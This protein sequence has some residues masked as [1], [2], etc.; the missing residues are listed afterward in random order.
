MAGA[1]SG[2]GTGSGAVGVGLGGFG[3]GG[4]AGGIVTA[5]VTGATATTGASSGGI[6]AQSLGGGGGDGGFAIAGA[7]S[8]AGTG[9]GSVGVGIGGFGGDGGGGSDVTLGVTGDTSTL[10]GDSAGVTAQSIG[11]GGGNGGFSVGAALSFAGKGAGAVGV[12]IGGFGGAGGGAGDVRLTL[13]GDTDTRGIRSTGILAQSIGGGG[14]N[15]GFTV[16]GSVAGASTGA[17]ALSVGIGGFGGDAS[18][19]G[20][21]TAAVTGTTITTAAQSGAIIAQS[22]GGGGGNGGF[23]IAGAVA[24]ASDGAGSG[25]IGIGGF[26]G[27]GG[28]A[29]TVDLTAA[30]ATGRGG[31]VAMTGGD[32]AGGVL[33]Q[34][35]GGGGGNGGFTVAGSVTLTK[36]TGAALSVGVGG[37]GGSGG[38]ASD[39]TAAVTGYVGTAGAQSTGVAAQSLGGGGGNGGMAISGALSLSSDKAGALAVGIGGFG[40]GGGNATAV[41]LTR[42]GDTVTT[43]GNSD[44]VVAQAIG[45]GGGSGGMSIAG[46]VTL[47]LSGQAGSIALGLGGFGGDG[48]RAGAVV[49]TLTGSIGTGYSTTPAVSRGDTL[50]GYTLGQDVGGNGFVAQSIGGGGGNGGL[51]ISGAVAITNPNKGDAAA[52][53]IGIGGFGGAGGDAGT[54]TANVSGAGGAQG[55]IVANGDGNSAILAQSIGGGGGN[56]GID[57]AG[58]IAADGNLTPGV[59]GLGGAGGPGQAVSGAARSDL[60]AGGIGSAGLVAQSLGGGGGNG[61]INI[62]GGITFDK[63]SKLPNL[64]VGIG[65]FGGA[66]NTAGAVKVDQAGT[67]TVD[68]GSTVGILAQSIGGGGGRG[69]INVTAAGSGSTEKTGAAIGVGVGGNGGT[70]ADAGT[71]DVVSR[72]QIDV[73]RYT[74]AAVLGS[75]NTPVV[76]PDLL[77][78]LGLTAITP[79][80]T[81]TAGILA[82]SVGGGGGVGGF[83]GGLVVAPQGSVLS[84]AVGG[85][86]GAA[87]NADT[88]GVTRGYILNPD[89]SRTVAAA[90][91]TTFGNDASGLVAQ[92]VGGGGGLAGATLSLAASKLTDTSKDE[93][94]PLFASIVV[95]GAGGAAGNGSTVTVAQN[96]SIT[97]HGDRSDGI[98]AQSIGGGGGNANYSI[99]IGAARKANALSLAVGGDPASGGTGGKV[100]VDQVGAITTSGIDSVGIRAQSIGGGGGNT[101]TTM[102][103]ALKANNKVSVSIGRAGGAGGAAD[104]VTVGAAGSITTS[105][106]GGYG[107]LAQSIGGGGG[108]S[109]AVS[110]GTTTTDTND[111]STGTSMSIGIEGGAGATAGKV[112]VTSAA[113]IATQGVNARGILAQS[114]GGGGGVGGMATAVAAFNAAEYGLSLGGAGGTGAAAST[115]TVTNSGAISTVGSDAEAI[116]A[117]SVGGGGGI[118]GM[119]AIMGLQVSGGGSGTDQTTMNIGVGG[120]GGVG[121]TADHVSVTNSAALTTSG[122]NSYGIRAESIG[123]GGGSGGAVANVLL[124]G[125]SE[126]TRVA[127][128]V[129]GS[130]GEGAA[131]GAI[132][133]ANSGAITTTGANATG[134]VATSVG[135]GGGSGGMVIDFV[136][137][138]AGDERS[139]QFALNIGG[140]G[141]V[142]GTGGAVSVVNDTTGVIKTSGDAAYGILAQ[143]IGGGGGRGS[144]I[145]SVTAVPSSA[146]SLLLG[147]SV[148]GV[149]GS[150]NTGGDVSV[151]NRGLIQTSGADAHGI[152]AQS[153]GGGGGNGGMVLSGITG[154]TALKGT[155]S[156]AVG[157]VG[158]DGGDA[159]KV[160]VVNTGTILTSG[161]GADGIRAQSVGGGGGNAN[162]A[163]NVGSSAAALA[164]N[165]LNGLLGAVGGGTGGQ[166][167]VVD[168]QQNGT[169]VVSGDNAQAVNIQSV[170]GG[171][172]TLTFDLSGI[173]DLVGTPL[174]PTQTLRTTIAVALGAQQ[175]ADTKAATVTVN[176]VGDQV[177]AG[178]GGSGSGVQSIGGGGGTAYLNLKFVPTANTPAPVARTAVARIAARGVGG[179]LGAS[180]A[181][182]L[183]P[184]LASNVT[185]ALGGTGGAGNGG[186]ATT[187]GVTGQIVTTG[188][189]T[190]GQI[191]Q[192]IGGGGGRISAGLDT[193]LATPGA[194][195]ITLGGIGTAAS[196]GGAVSVTQSG[197][198]ATDGALAPGV[199]LQSIGGG[200]GSVGAYLSAGASPGAIATVGL[201]GNGGTGAD[202]GA[203]TAS[204]TGGIQT[205]GGDSVGVLAQSI[206]G[207]GGEVRLADIGTSALAIGGTGG[208]AGKGGA[209]SLTN[210]GTIRTSGARSHAVLLQS[211]GGGGGAGFGALGGTLT[212]NAAN[213]GDGGAIGFV[214]QGDVVT[215]GDGAFG[216]IAQSIGGGGGWLDGLFAG[217]AGG[218]GRGGTVTLSVTGNVVTTGA[219]ATGILAQ[220]L[221]ALGAGDITVAVS[222]AVRGGGGTGI[223]VAFDGGRTNTLNVGGSVSA[224][225]NLAIQGTTGNDTVNNAGLVYGNVQ[226]AAGGATAD[227]NRFNNA[228][229]AFFVPF[230]TVGLGQAGL[231]ANAGTFNP[232]DVGRLQVT[233]LTG[234]VTQSAT[235]I[236]FTD[237]DFNPVVQAQFTDRVNVSGTANLTGAVTTVVANV[238][239]IQAG[240]RQ[241]VLVDTAGGFTNGGLTLNAPV[242]A[243]AR[244]S[245]VT[246]P[247]Q[248]NLREQIDFAGVDRVLNRNRTE[249]GDYFNRIQAAGSSAALAPVITQLFYTPDV[250]TLGVLYDSFGAEIYADQIASASYSGD[251]FAQRLTKCADYGVRYVNGGCTWLSVGGDRFEQRATFENRAYRDLGAHIQ[252]GLT[253]QLGTSPLTAGFAG[254]YETVHTRLS[255]AA[256]EGSRYQ[257]GLSLGYTRAAFDATA[258]GTF[259]H[260]S[261][262][263]TRL[264]ETPV[265]PSTATGRQRFDFG[266]VGGELGYTLKAGTLAVRPAL[267]GG[268]AYWQQQRAV[269][270]GAAM[271]SLSLQHPGT[272]GFGYIRPNVSASE[273]FDLGGV[274]F[275]AS[276]KAGYLRRFGDASVSAT[277]TGAPIGVTPFTTRS[278]LDRDA[279]TVGASL[280]ADLGRGVSLQASY[281]GEFGQRT[282]AHSAMGTLRIAF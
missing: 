182:A 94:T 230:E 107:I 29:D 189:D 229:G 81:V 114:I 109:S 131:A 82:Q 19:G 139:R 179:T 132:D 245:L 201:G 192:S 200:G 95:G 164:G 169:I 260:G 3:G 120:S 112:A 226:L 137:G 87:G 141:G 233:A 172:G 35:L 267:D 216:I 40:G 46:S 84:L 64:T 238:P 168:V 27:G 62:S 154:G 258:Y 250:A 127:I 194:I 99:G 155:Q 208:V 21:V 101:A 11:G 51:N 241:S 42:D 58:G 255:G 14:G 150:G 232:G 163:I 54:V 28:N 278:F 128:N 203:I 13:I 89:G 142:G 30:S 135:G 183:A 7:L 134:I 74:S 178:R 147:L 22:L 186:A 65:G 85:S 24:L 158:G 50:P 111:K 166:A 55:A 153:I 126:N 176:T 149:G 10:G 8:A 78:S 281:D 165:V 93:D 9:S 123:G 140:S 66:G 159:G 17:A 256:G 249:V 49:S 76:A 181:A 26:G 244:F 77:A 273:T 61:G 118:G 224:I 102:A 119:V 210:S 220:S 47:G 184:A 269:E 191:V 225:S 235:G 69:G 39:V 104:D 161:Q 116:L 2:G 124:Q 274:G 133:V 222:G 211:I 48:G 167:G 231:L 282:T 53:A 234:S 108:A 72:G 1:L 31:V 259:G 129:G 162:V 144:S 188:T 4:G 196:P 151:T 237:L 173:T 214:Q 215:I 121:A 136:A 180:A 41:T 174:D 20:A 103:L 160:T 80:S 157:G 240:D 185:L 90:S 236:Y 270:S 106:Q 92:S 5:S 18:A 71:V 110:I 115:V 23:A 32:G 56:G 248:L 204:Y 218:Q 98:I 79:V 86:G 113:V 209:V 63:T 59:G 45:G 57:I 262:G 100:I 199:I 91:L 60:Y 146:D 73:N 246:S 83:D 138:Y 68:G 219:D 271:L 52:A 254:S 272:K 261:I 275:G 145:V 148:G 207:G 257:L 190:P 280:R 253:H 15:G 276:L 12:G 67:I 239:I 228:I 16:A 243:I 70:G 202:G 197:G 75:G 37:F 265:A 212:R 187:L 33:A 34:S 227:V 251:R 193:S 277:F 279:G 170:N 175:A 6:L 242:S 88:V 156:I 263:V 117:Q 38:D 177:V 221:G 44:A 36:G 96:G 105:G 195:D 97:T 130:G 43:G 252:G 198:I 152:F 143:S 266:Q 223:G 171:G 264:V 206:G 217:S 125:K 205:S 122:A 247:K 213:S 268:Y 25:S